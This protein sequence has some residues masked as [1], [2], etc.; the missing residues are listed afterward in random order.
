MKLVEYADRDMLMINLAQQLAGE[1]NTALM[2]NDTASFAVPGGTTPGPAFDA[3]CAADLDWSRVHVMPT[4]ER[5]VDESSERS[6]ARLI[7][8]RLLTNRAADATFVPFYEKGVTPDNAMDGLAARLTSALPLSVLLLGMGADMHTASLFPGAPQLEQAL[9][10]DA[11]P[12]MPVTPAGQETRI[13]LTGP[14]LAGA[15]STHVLITGEE[16]RAALAQ[17]QSL[18]MSEAPINTVLAN[19]TVHWAA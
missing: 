10:Q 9:S 4:D 15:V 6:N 14:V 1:L 3:L 7:K 12:A 17:A 2:S 11:P 8:Q 19:A 16:K 13:T 5:W 18:S